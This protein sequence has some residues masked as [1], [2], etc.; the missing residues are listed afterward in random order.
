NESNYIYCYVT[1]NEDK[2]KCLRMIESENGVAQIEDWTIPLTEKKTFLK[3]TVKKETAQFHLKDVSTEEWKKV[4]PQKNMCILSGG[5]TGNFIG[6][7]VHDLNK[8][9]GSYADFEFFKYD[10]KDHL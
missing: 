2:G 5:F 10:G 3:V 8:K 1:W 9:R 4:G 6:I 7:A